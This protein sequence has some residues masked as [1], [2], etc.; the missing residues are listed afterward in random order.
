MN[1]LILYSEII[2]EILKIDN[3]F[4]VREIRHVIILNYKI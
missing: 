3:I 1:Y 2:P 4:K